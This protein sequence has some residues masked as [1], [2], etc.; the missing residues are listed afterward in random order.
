[1]ARRLRWARFGGSGRA[2]LPLLPGPSVL[3]PLRKRKSRSPSPA[4]PLLG[5]ATKA[6]YLKRLEV[7]RLAAKRVRARTRSAYLLALMLLLAFL[8]L[9]RLPTWSAETWDATLEAFCEDLFDKGGSISRV[10]TLMCALV[11]ARPAL[12]GPVRRLFPRTSAAVKGWSCVNPPFSRP[13]LPREVMLAITWWLCEQGMLGMGLICLLMFETYA[14]PSEALALRRCSIVLGLPG[15]QGKARHMTII[16]RASALE[17]PGKTGEFDMS[18]PLDLARQGWLQHLLTIWCRDL[19]PQ[20]PL[21]DF[22][23]EALTHWLRKAC[24]ALDLAPLRPS[25]YQF[26]H[27]GASHDRLV[28]ARPLA[29]VQHRGGWK[30][31]SSVRRYE[32]HG[33]VSM[34]LQK[35]QPHV[36]RKVMSL[37]KSAAAVCVSIFGMLNARQMVAPGGSFSSSLQARR[38]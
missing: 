11:W 6:V 3:L 27:G 36:L 4:P 17:V 8:R 13:P 22:D 29:E 7:P 19:A 1:M 32:K 5:M 10:R 14:R 23:L 30:A 21:W 16:L 12:E 35:L 24:D 26:R 33:R 38:A 20:D 34:E 18:I 15:G 31:F 37:A 25:A 9:G 28:E 2:A